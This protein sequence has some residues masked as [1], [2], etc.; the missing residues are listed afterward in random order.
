MNAAVDM[1]DIA[2][3][4]RVM[5]E[6]VTG[7]WPQIAPLLA[8]DLSRTRT[9]VPEDVRRMIMIGAAHLWIQYDGKVQ[10]CCVTEFVSYPLG[11]ALRVW[12]GE[13]APGERMRRREFRELL[14]KFAQLHD[15]RWLEAVGRHGWMKVFP[16]SEYTGMLMRIVVGEP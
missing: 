4:L 15:C 1:S 2:P 12:L 10:A 5:P 14:G 9:H 16:E 13:A 11:L 6:N 8:V 3:I 7:L